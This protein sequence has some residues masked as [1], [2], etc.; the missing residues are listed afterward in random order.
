MFSGMGTVACRHVVRQLRAPHLDLEGLARLERRQAAVVDVIVDEEHVL[1][2]VGVGRPAAGDEVDAV[3]PRRRVPDLEAVEGDVLEVGHQD[4][5]RPPAVEDGALRG[6]VG[7][8][9]DGRRRRPRD[10][11][12]ERAGIGA[13]LDPD[14]VAGLEGGLVVVVEGRPGRRLAHAVVRVAARRRDVERPLRD[15]PLQDGG[16]ERAARRRGVA[17]A[18]ARRRASARRRGAAAGGRRPRGRRRGASAAGRRVR[19]GG[20]ARGEQRAAR[21]DEGE[22]ERHRR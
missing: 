14:L 6:A 12:E 7:D 2:Q 5:A 3:R 20:P 4:R 18:A 15:E 11:P 16:R 22:G 10:R 13:R 17:S 8:E 1:R 9:V 19:A 21:G